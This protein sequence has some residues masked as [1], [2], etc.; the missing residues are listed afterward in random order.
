M[1]NTRTRQS[2][3]LSSGDS[4][5]Y[6]SSLLGV[7]LPLF[8]RFFHSLYI[9]LSICRLLSILSERPCPSGG[10]LSTSNFFYFFLSLCVLSSLYFGRVQILWARPPHG[11]RNLTLNFALC[12]YALEGINCLSRICLVWHPY[13]SST[14]FM[15]MCNHK[16]AP[17]GLFSGLCSYI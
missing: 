5:L 11:V 12:F 14:I 2:T 9:L 7:L 1:P 17:S 4:L 13:A 3:S 6:V 15:W 16:E 8:R 10:F